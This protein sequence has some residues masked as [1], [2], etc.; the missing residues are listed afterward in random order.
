MVSFIDIM[1]MTE[2][3]ILHTEK[4]KKKYS[5][6]EKEIK[7]V[8]NEALLLNNMWWSH[9]ISRG[10]SITKDFQIRQLSTK[11]NSKFL[12][13]PST[14]KSLTIN[15]TIESIKENLTKL[16]NDKVDDEQIASKYKKWISEFLWNIRYK[17]LK[18][19]YPQ[20]KDCQKFRLYIK[21]LTNIQDI[22]KKNIKQQLAKILVSK[23]WDEAFSEK[24]NKRKSKEKY[25]VLSHKSLDYLFTIFYN[26]NKVRESRGKRLDQVFHDGDFP[27][28]TRNVKA[29]ESD[30]V[31]VIIY[32][33][34]KTKPIYY[35]KRWPRWQKQRS[36]K[37]AQYADILRA[38]TNDQLWID[39][40]DFADKNSPEFQWD[41]ITQ[42]I[43][44]IWW[45]LLDNVITTHNDENTTNKLELTKRLKSISSCVEKI[46]E[47]KRINDA[48]WLRLSSR[49]ISGKNLW[50][51]E[52]ISR[53]WFKDFKA[54]LKKY[55]EKY[56]PGYTLESWQTISIKEVRIDN[57]WVLDAN[58]MDEIIRYLNQNVNSTNLSQKN[59]NSNYIKFFK[60][61]SPETPYIDSQERESRIKKHYPEIYNDP[62]KLEI[63]KWFYKRISNGAS[64]GKNGLYKDFKFNIVVEIKDKEERSMWE[65]TMELQFDDI[66]NGKWLAN[67]NIRNFERWINTQSRLSFSVPLCEA[68]KMCEKCLKDMWL[69]A[70]KWTAE[71]VSSQEKQDFFKIDFYDGEPPINISWFWKR[72]AK[73]DK[74]MDKAI[75]KII[76]YFI[77]KWTLIL[78]DNDEPWNSAIKRSLLTTKDLH[79]RDMMENLHICSSLEL[80]SEQHSYLQQNRDRK[81][82]VY[83]EDQNK[84]G[85]TSVWE[86]IDPM[87]LWKKKDPK[88]SAWV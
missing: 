73:N 74:L 10:L 81:V 15:N 57:K 20:R 34:D 16:I 67:Y 87:N 36:K 8:L 29:T 23:F 30:Y 22:K 70:K 26:A 55:P 14:I 51:I 86:L 44:K 61:E 37:T 40:L 6:V 27:F 58:Q 17:S 42:N 72:D 21:Q 9:N 48:I 63:I 12:S 76:N 3:E 47:W 85:W 11:E 49:W 41:E 53:D 83:L 79:D 38:L 78:C 84:I 7:R 69:W 32:L 62:E 64:R 31:D 33:E 45:W 80:A 35:S 5:N 1:L 75:V 39:K 88:Y 77:Q 2:K 50:E 25:I 19:S 13:N 65:R 56:I 52:Q 66:N 18:E 54:S 68:R 4:I 60:R 28:I 59:A 46:I 82:W 71:W 43:Y 24:P